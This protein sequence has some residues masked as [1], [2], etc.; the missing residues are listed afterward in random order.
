MSS[1]PEDRA[2]FEVMNASHARLLGREL[3]ERGARWL[4]RE[5]PFVV[6]AHGVGPDPVFTYA[7]RAAQTCF[8]YDRE[9]FLTLPS[10][11]SAEADARDSRRRVFDEV[12]RSG[13]VTGYSGV[14]VTKTGRRFRIEDAT[15]WR[16][17]DADG[18]FLGEAATF[19]RWVDLSG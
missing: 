17:T 14:R 9:S 16:L 6:L 5:A 12:A 1:D 18:A 13:F 8:G 19:A 3:T 7:N 11:L 10:R 4:Y 15:I 2:L